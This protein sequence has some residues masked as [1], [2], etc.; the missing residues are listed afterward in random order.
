MGY[1]GSDGSALAGA[2]NPSGIVAALNLDGS[3]NLKTNPLPGGNAVTN[4]CITE[5]QIR[6]WLI[7][8][9][10]F[11]ATY[12]QTIGAAAQGNFALSIFNPAN[13]GKS[14]LIFSSKVTLNYSIYTVGN[15]LL[16][17]T[18]PTYN[19]AIT[20]ANLKAGSSTASIASVTANSATT[21]WPSGTNIDTSFAIP[22]MLTNNAAILLPPGN[23]LVSALYVGNSQEYALA[24]KWVE[25]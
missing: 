24:A 17:T 15:L 23:G 21:T 7:N 13:S 12:N 5:D 1:I 16:N 18:D 14:I 2:L 4:P 19:T 3:G 22:E 25:F 20:P 10:C 8:G 11:S 6:G 9:Q